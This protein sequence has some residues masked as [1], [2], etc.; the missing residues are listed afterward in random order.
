LAGV[1]AYTET[2]PLAQANEAYQR[3]MANDA[4]FRVV[5]TMS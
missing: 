4:R 3:M 5:L 2:Y 1:R